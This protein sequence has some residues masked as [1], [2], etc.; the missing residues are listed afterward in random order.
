VI[1]WVIECLTHGVNDWVMKFVA[2]LRSVSV[3]D[4]VRTNLGALGRIF[5]LSL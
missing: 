5:Y 4:W 3:S 1:W 2:W